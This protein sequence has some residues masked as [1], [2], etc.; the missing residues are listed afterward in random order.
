MVVDTHAHNR[1]VVCT[2]VHDNLRGVRSSVRKA[3]TERGMR[4]G[5]C[6]IALPDRVQSSGLCLWELLCNCTTAGT[7]VLLKPMRFKHPDSTQMFVVREQLT[8]TTDVHLP[9]FLRSLS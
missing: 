7:N 3:M 8:L 9:T 6:F 4:K 5:I 1:L 2:Q